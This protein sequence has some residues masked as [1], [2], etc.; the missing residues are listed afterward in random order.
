[1]VVDAIGS[2]TVVSFI[3][4]VKVVF[5]SFVFSAE[6]VDSLVFSVEVAGIVDV[7]FAV[8]STVIVGSVAF[9]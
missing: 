5:T 2:V 4:S 9:V 3:V 6:V 7:D 1:M 8:F